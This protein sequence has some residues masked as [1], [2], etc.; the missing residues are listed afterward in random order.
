[1]ET[2]AHHIVAGGSKYAKE[3]RMI[4]AKFKI[5]INDAAN[6]VFLDTAKHLGLHTKEYY[7]KVHKALEKATTREAVIDTLNTIAKKLMEGTF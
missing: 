3:K 4:L 1:M 5:V 6:G 2:A 7:R